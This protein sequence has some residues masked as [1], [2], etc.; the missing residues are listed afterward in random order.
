MSDDHPKIGPGVML[1]GLAWDVGLPLAAYYGLHAL[2]A[3]DWTAL[4]A[5]T[6]MAG[7]RIVWVAVRDRRLKL[8]ATMMLVVFGLGVMLSFVS[9]D[10]R[11]LLLKDSITT[12]AVGLAFLVTSLRGTPLTLAAAQG[13]RPN[14]ASGSRSSTARIRWCAAPTR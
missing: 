14:A 3:S 2:G 9:G 10:A 6:G 11:F 4:L 12:A 8:F 1:R 13:F 5:A 7:M